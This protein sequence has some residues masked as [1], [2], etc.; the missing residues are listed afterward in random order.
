MC[1]H[2]Q[3]YL[4]HGI[5]DLNWLQTLNSIFNSGYI[6]TRES[7]KKYLDAFQYQVFE[8]CHTAN[9]NGKN[10]ISIACHPDDMECIH[11]YNLKQ[12][13][14]ESAYQ[15]FI[16]D[17]YI[18]LVLDKSLLDV[19]EIKQKSLKLNYELQILGDIPI[20]YVVAIATP[21]SRKKYSAKDLYILENFLLKLNHGENSM[22]DNNILNLLEDFEHIEENFDK[23]SQYLYNIRNLIH[24]YQLDIPIIDLDYGY[25]LPDQDIQKQKLLRIKNQYL[26]YIKRN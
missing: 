7:L 9:W 14:S 1:F 21:D 17:S 26:Q 13:S 12:N 3:D 5:T 15:D 16:Y 25:V 18:S 24:T 22:E 20:Q 11:K 19:F 10:S 8:D 6:Y 23:S 4:Y 2:L